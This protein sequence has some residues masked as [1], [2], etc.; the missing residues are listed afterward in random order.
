MISQV[1]FE[2]LFDLSV[3]YILNLSSLIAPSLAA[4]L[5]T[6]Q[7]QNGLLLQ[8]GAFLILGLFWLRRTRRATGV[9]QA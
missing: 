8:G 4:Y 5:D 1:A 7:E 2:R 6:S 3:I 9:Q